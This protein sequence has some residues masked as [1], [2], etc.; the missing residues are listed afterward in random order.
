MKIKIEMWDEAHPRWDELKRYVAEN[1]PSPYAMR[2]DDETLHFYAGI[3]QT[4]AGQLVGYHVFLVQP[5]GPEMDVPALKNGSG[6]VLT[7]AKI[8]V[9]FVEE[10]LRGQGIGT[11][12][13]EATLRFAGQLGCFQ[14]RSRS[15]LDK[16]ANY[17][18]KMRLGFACHPAARTLSNGDVDLGVYWV[19]RTN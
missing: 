8:R 15:S 2:D 5:I 10:F 6:N 16:V 17:R 12:L 11:R 9:L 14:M 19:K 3:A 18:I 4:E 7:E 1:E 13:Q